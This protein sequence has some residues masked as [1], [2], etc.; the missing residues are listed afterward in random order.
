M[1]PHLY[2]VAIVAAVVLTGTAGWAG[3]LAGA[4]THVP[5]APIGHLQ[6]RAP[7]FSASSPSEQ[8]EQQ[9]MSN[10]DAKQE[11]LDREL[12]RSLNICRC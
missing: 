9:Q 6:P 4:M 12:D 2:S 1:R 8:D 11:K 3:P 5:P 10:F 7:Q